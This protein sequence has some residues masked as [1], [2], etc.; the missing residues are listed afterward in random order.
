[1]VRLYPEDYNPQASERLPDEWKV[2]TNNRGE[3][4]F[5]QVAAGTYNIHAAHPEKN[6]VTL[7]QDVEV[8]ED[9]TEEV[10][11]GNNLL[12]EPGIIRVSLTGLT[13]EE[14][15][16]IYI[17]GTGIYTRVD[18]AALADGYLTL[19]AVPAGTYSTF[20]YKGAGKTF[21]LTIYREISLNASDTAALGEIPD[22]KTVVSGRITDE[23]GIPAAGAVVRLVPDSYNPLAGVPLPDSLMDFTDAQGSYSFNSISSG[24]YHM[25][26]IDLNDG[27]RL[28]GGSISVSGDTT[29]VPDHALQ[30][31]GTVV[32]YFP[33]SI[34]VEG[35][36]LFIPLKTSAFCHL[37]PVLSVPIMPGRI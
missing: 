37:R 1:M 30:Q 3:Y 6:T 7:V 9:G 22:T 32:L 36:Y 13:V 29:T 16:Y 31:P 21:D 5:K 23:N 34:V 25:E 14:D 26:A 20:E 18:S 12:L 28:A 11:T 4:L 10:E 27:S 19:D 15:G 8:T 24:T 35:G 17:P 33:D 2:K